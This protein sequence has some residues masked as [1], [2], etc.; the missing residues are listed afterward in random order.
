M[1][2]LFLPLIRKHRVNRGSL[3]QAENWNRCLR[4]YNIVSQAPVRDTKNLI[5]TDTK[6]YEPKETESNR[7]IIS[8]P[9]EAQTVEMS[10]GWGGEEESHNISPERALQYTE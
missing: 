8:S 5:F 6:A 4:Q 1:N 10:R 7:K 2:L 9:Q 3:S